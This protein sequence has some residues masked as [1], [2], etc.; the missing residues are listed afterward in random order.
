MGGCCS[1]EVSDDG[2]PQGIQLGSIGQPQ[3]VQI[4]VP[5]NRVDSQG[6]PIAPVTRDMDGPTLQAALDIVSSFIHRYDQ[7]IR[8]VAVGGA[9]NLLYLRSRPATHDVDVFG[10]DFSNENRMLID[11][12]MQEAQRR[13]PALGTD[14]LNTETQMWIPGRLHAELTR[15]SERQD[16][17]IYDRP[18]LTILAAPWDYAYSAKINRILRPQGQARAYDMD[19]AVVY[20]HEYIQSHGNQPLQVSACLGWAKEYQHDSNEDIL[21]RH[22]NPAYRRRYGRDAFVR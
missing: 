11:D 8:I 7:H 12:A 16:V 3:N 1:S 19:D 15:R 20:L 5:R 2:H 22:V 14:W 13:I 9:V 10:S 6:V 17:R 4:H 21:L 18:G